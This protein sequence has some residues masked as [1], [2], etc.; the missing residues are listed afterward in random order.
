MKTGFL[1][2]IRLRYVMYHVAVSSR[3]KA[4]GSEV[5]RSYVITTSTVWVCVK[6]PVVYSLTNALW[7]PGGGSQAVLYMY[8]ELTHKN[9][10]SA[11][12]STCRSAEFL[13]SADAD[14]WC[15]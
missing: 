4:A 10:K 12:A 6:W 2:V 5:K 15:G 9:V 13:E 1:P 7:L 11:D 3:K 8:T 14:Y